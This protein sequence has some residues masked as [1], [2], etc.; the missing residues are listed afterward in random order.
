MQPKKLL[1]LSLRY[2]GRLL[3]YSLGASVI[4]SLSFIFTGGLS[5]VALSE[6]IFWAG[7]VVMM[8][9]VVLV[10][11]ISSVGTG[12]GLPGMIRHPHEA[13]E[14]MEKNLQ[15]RGALEKRYDLCIL[16]WLAGMGCIGI[17]ALVQVYSP[18][19]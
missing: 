14:L 15:L 13:K 6:R 1:I 4:A 19:K 3:L 16:L 9:S 11:A 5:S 2:I 12:M 8:T 18:W 17:S 7:M 10:I